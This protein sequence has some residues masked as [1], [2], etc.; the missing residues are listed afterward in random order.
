MI[1]NKDPHPQVVL[2]LEE[3]TSVRREELSGHGCMAEAEAAEEVHMEGGRVGD[4]EEAWGA[5]CSGS[6]TR[7]KLSASS[8]IRSMKGKSLTWNSA[9]WSVA[10]CILTRNKLSNRKPTIRGTALNATV[11][12]GFSSKAW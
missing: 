8:T 3:C 11:L 6:E 10:A 4:V 1:S 9:N 5:S 12:S 7:V 2:D